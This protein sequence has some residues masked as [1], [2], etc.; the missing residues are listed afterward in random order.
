MIKKIEV[1]EYIKILNN[2]VKERKLKIK[3][4]SCKDLA[5]EIGVT[6]ATISNLTRDSKLSLILEISERIS[7]HYLELFL[8]ERKE[9]IMQN[10]EEKTVWAKKYTIYDIMQDLIQTEK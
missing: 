2:E 1:A 3:K 4:L 9:S 8:I 10:I 6:P 5:E 7:D